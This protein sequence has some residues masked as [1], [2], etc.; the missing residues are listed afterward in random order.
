M[1]GESEAPIWFWSLGVV[2]SAAL[3]LVLHGSGSVRAADQV[4]T[5]ALSTSL[6]GSAAPWGIP[7]K[8]AT[9]PVFEELN[10]HTRPSCM[11]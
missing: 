4:L 10:A 1:R 7:H 5:F 8:Q 6:S 9:E 11:S 2:V 3:I